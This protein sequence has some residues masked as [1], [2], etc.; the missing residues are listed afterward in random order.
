M[1]TDLQLDYRLR[2]MDFDRY[3]RI[4]PAA[5]LDIFQDVATIQAIS[6]G[7]GNADMQA[8][9]VFWVVVRMKYEIVRQPER[10]QVVKARTWPHTLS[11]F[12]FLRDYEMTDEQ[13][14]VLVKASSEWVLLSRE[15]REFVRMSDIYDGTTDFCEDRAFERKP[16]KVAAFEGD[17]RLTRTIVPAYSDI[18]QN[19]H[20]NNA[21]YAGFVVDALDPGAEGEIRTFQID[22]RHEVLPGVPLEMQL[23]VQD[24]RV[25]AKGINPDGEI[26][27]AC[28]M[29]LA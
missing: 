8:K 5:I 12:S 6:M 3:G 21:K 4:Q 24:G 14:N 29:E 13:G 1:A 23:L 18:D 22:Y 15:T 2:W 26:A 20:V 11:R 10:L 17:P 9:G 7:I 25:L 16:R 28:D 19:G 27:F